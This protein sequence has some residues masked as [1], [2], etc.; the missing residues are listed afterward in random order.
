MRTAF[1][2]RTKQSIVFMCKKLL[3]ISFVLIPLFSFAQERS[4]HAL[5]SDS[6]MLHAS[7]SLSVADSESGEKVLEYNSQKSLIPASVMKLI[8][9]AA[10][11]ELL[12]PKYTF[13]TMMGYTG[14]L[15]K[16]TGRL[17]GDLVI[18]GGGDPALGSK[19]F[20]DHYGDFPGSWITEIKRIGIKR[21]DGRV[22]IDDSYYDYQPV[23]GKWLWEDAGN[24]YGAGVYGLSVFDNT[25]EIHF[26]TTDD[27]LNMIITKVIPPEC[28]YE[29]SNRLFARGTLTNMGYVFA[30]PYSTN[31]WLD[32]TIPVNRED[33]ILKAS[34]PDPPLLLAE[35]FDNK[36]DSAGLIISGNPSTTRIEKKSVSGEFIKVTEIVSPSLEEIIEVL[37]HESVNLYAENLTKELGKVFKNNGSTA[38]GVGVINQFLTD[39]GININGLFIEDGSGLSP[40]N[41]INAG[42]LTNLLVCM[43]QRGRYFN[44]YYTSLPDAGKEGTLKY[45]FRDPVFD[46]NLKA[47]SGS[48]TRVRSYS[49]YFKTLSGKMMAFS[50]IVNNY[51]GPAQKIISGIEDII[52][53]IILYK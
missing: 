31:G 43:K 32:G 24:Y 38:S 10:A 40:L 28:S 44:E 9:S 3:F 7:I 39:E 45:Y 25:Y 20:K 12:G 14:T 22:L 35:I 17:T 52:K 30:A 49:G 29:L 6:S 51:T 41:S 46:S 36:L 26:K 48:M 4:I 8:T 21:I 23:P 34:I 16:R 27:S 15:N 13:R 47:K 50:I 11:M 53:E 37:N 33:F 5:L 42:E 2:H 19:Y 18:K 1:Y